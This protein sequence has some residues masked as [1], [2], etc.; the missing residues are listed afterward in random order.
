M[1]NR[2]KEP[3]KMDLNELTQPL[4]LIIILATVLIPVFIFV[5]SNAINFE[6]MANLSNNSFYQSKINSNLM[7]APNST[8]GNYYSCEL[9][10]YQSVY[11]P[12]ENGLEMQIL[13]I[14]FLVILAI[15]LFIAMYYS[16]DIRIK[17]LN[18]IAIVILLFIIIEMNL[19]YVIFYMS[20]TSPFN[21]QAFNKLESLL[22]LLS[23]PPLLFMAYFLRRIIFIIIDKKRKINILA[24][25]LIIIGF[26]MILI[27]C[28]YS[29]QA[30]TR[31]F[32]TIENTLTLLNYIY[33]FLILALCG[34]T[35]FLL[36][37]L[38]LPSKKHRRYK[39]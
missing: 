26:V 37:I 3:S 33:L 13:F 22:I 39:K 21:I 1:K 28:S 24:S 25:I 34:E 27:G 35:T 6:A 15:F 31:L 11:V 30:L 9:N 36:G 18:S 10:I 17:A 14:I 38:L 16:K 20:F 2:Q 7:C 23:I 29:Q 4:E 12:L 32:S 19:F 5:S 8:I